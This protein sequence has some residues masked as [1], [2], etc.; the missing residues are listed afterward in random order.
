LRFFGFD[1]SVYSNLRRRN[2]MEIKG[3]GFGTF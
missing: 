3:M 1:R 2:S